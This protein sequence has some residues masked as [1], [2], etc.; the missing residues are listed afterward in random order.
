[1]TAP[2]NALAR[3]CQRFAVLIALML[4]TQA[5]APFKYIFSR[6]YCRQRIYAHA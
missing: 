5:H 4:S 2:L 3:A 6:R 1:M